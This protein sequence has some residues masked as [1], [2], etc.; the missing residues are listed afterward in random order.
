MIAEPWRPHTYAAKC[1]DHT[2]CHHVVPC[3]SCCSCWNPVNFH[4][5]FPLLLSSLIPFSPPLHFPPLPHPSITLLHPPTWETDTS[6]LVIMGLSMRL[7]APVLPWLPPG[8]TQSSPLLNPTA[9]K[10]AVQASQENIRSAV[11][12]SWQSLPEPHIQKKKSK[13]LWWLKWWLKLLL[14]H[15]CDTPHS[16]HKENLLYISLCKIS[17]IKNNLV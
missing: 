15:E 16:T 12:L 6:M 14:K 10:S 17:G 7:A 4:L 5:Y 11:H 8:V 9:K 3:R 13:E 1:Y 2:V